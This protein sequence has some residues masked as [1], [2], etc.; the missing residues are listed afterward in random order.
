MKLIATIATAAMAVGFYSYSE[1]APVSA[2][3][4]IVICEQQNN[5]VVTCPACNGRGSFGPNNACLR[6]K[7][8]GI[9]KANG[10]PW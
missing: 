6:C 5:G 9:V 4:D 2:A 8:R 1:A 7:G 10:M 3:K